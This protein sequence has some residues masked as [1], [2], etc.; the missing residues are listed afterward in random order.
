MEKNR[1]AISIGLFLLYAAAGAIFAHLVFSCIVPDSVTVFGTFS[2]DPI[3]T[4]VE[5]STTITLT[6]VFDPDGAVTALLYVNKPSSTNFELVG[7]MIPVGS[8][9]SLS[10]LLDEKGYYAVKAVLSDN[11]KGHSSVETGEVSVRVEPIGVFIYSVTATPTE[12]EQVTLKNNYNH[13]AD[14]GGWTIGDAN[15]PEDYTI[16]QNRMIAGYGGKIEFPHTT[17]GFWINDN[18]ET[19]YLKNPA[20]ELIDVWYD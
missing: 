10:L 16:P 19:I 11:V 4:T 1:R 3:E 12:E 17:L 18:G 15:N 20:G 7:A 14:L 6:D 13:E 8:S 5:N 9:Y 2:A